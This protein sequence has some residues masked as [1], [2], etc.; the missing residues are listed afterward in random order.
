M[1]TRRLI[2]CAHG[3]AE[4]AHFMTSTKKIS[5]AAHDYN[6]SVPTPVARTR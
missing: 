1:G 6:D 4:L 3:C 2:E 5:D